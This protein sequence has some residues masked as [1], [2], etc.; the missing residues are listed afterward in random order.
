VKK[1][2]CPVKK[3]NLARTLKNMTTQLYVFYMKRI[4]KNGRRNERS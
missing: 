3:E 2:A 4:N 1:C